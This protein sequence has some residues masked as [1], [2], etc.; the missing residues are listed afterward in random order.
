[1]KKFIQKLLFVA[2]CVIFFNALLFFVLSRDSWISSIENR[3]LSFFQ[4]NKKNKVYVIA[5]SSM[6]Y[7]FN[8]ELASEKL[9]M[10][11]FN[12]SFSLA[13]NAGFIL[14]YISDK[15]KEG[16]I[17]VYGPEYEFYYGITN[18]ISDAQSSSIYNNPKIFKYQNFYEKM[19][20]ISNIPKMNILLLYKRVK[21]KIKPGLF[22]TTCFNDRGDFDD[23][24]STKKT[25][26]SSNISKYLRKGY[27]G[28]TSNEFKKIVIKAQKKIER[29]GGKLF[30]TFPPFPKSEYDNR[31]TTDLER[32]YE[33]TTIK[34]IGSPDNYIFDDHYFLN[35]SYHTTALGTNLRTNVFIKEFQKK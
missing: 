14:N 28:N 26:V 4:N 30:V 27:N 32:F 22:N 8:S 25:W 29:K 9:G 18:S 6:G 20:F 2:G 13:H 5:G 33:D 24:E 21:M 12:V 11:F 7:S 34:L 15:I 1:M 19:N 16:D 23:F 35:H 3:K 31:F 17:V 10:E